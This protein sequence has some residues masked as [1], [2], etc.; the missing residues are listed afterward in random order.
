MKGEMGDTPDKEKGCTHGECSRSQEEEQEG[1]ELVWKA[2]WI[3]VQA[4]LCE[5][6][7]GRRITGFTVE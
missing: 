1:R 4:S 3:R 2:V 5:A 6:A 7:I